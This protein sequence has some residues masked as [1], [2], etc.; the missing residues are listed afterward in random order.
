ML[1]APLTSLLIGKPKSL[2]WSSNAHKAFE[3]LKE[4]FSA[5]PHPSSSRPPSPLRGG[6]KGML[7][8]PESGPYCRS[9]VGSFHPCTY[10]SRKLTPVESNYDIGNREMLTIK[11]NLEEWHHWLEVAHHHFTVITDNKHFQYLREA[12]RLNPRQAWWALFF[13][14][15]QFTIM[16]LS[17]KSQLQSQCSVTPALPLHTNRTGIH[18]LNRIQ[19]KCL[20]TN[21]F[22]NYGI[23]EEVD[24]DRGPQFISRVWKTFFRLLELTVSLSSGYHP[25][26]NGQT[27]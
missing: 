10:F 23:L 9:D 5:G 17:Q 15:F 20:F 8:P 3:R 11:L 22:R 1:T 25:Q 26:T 18:S 21:V 12:K 6:W 14:C 24:S 2:S 16:Y 13:T 19:S 7:P 4:A 27:E